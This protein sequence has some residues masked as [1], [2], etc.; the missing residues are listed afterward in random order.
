MAQRRVELLQ[1]VPIDGR[2]PAHDLEPDFLAERPTDIA[3]H[4]RQSADAVVERTHTASKRRAVQTVRELR[5]TTV[6]RIELDE[7]LREQT[8]T[9]VDRLSNL[10]KRRLATLAQ[11]VVP[12]R[13]L[14]HLERD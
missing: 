4:A 9:F 3:H 6:E 13:F 7:L 5:R 14:E 11:G 2:R 12:K 10:R 8:V 1:D